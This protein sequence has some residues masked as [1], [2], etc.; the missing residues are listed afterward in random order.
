MYA[1]DKKE[2]ALEWYDQGI[3]P[4]E[5]VRKLGSPKTRIT[6]Y[7]WIKQRKTSRSTPRNRIKVNN[8]PQHPLHPSAE[9]KLEIIKRCFARGE[10]VK[11]VSEETG[12]SRTSIYKG[13]TSNL[14]IFSQKVQYSVESPID[15][16]KGLMK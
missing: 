2:K 6:I 12:Y 8:S 9:V 4:T 5:I 11:L 1:Q 15:P 14:V 10:N 3:S 13:L 16:S 7:L